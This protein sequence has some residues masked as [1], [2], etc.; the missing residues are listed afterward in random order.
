MSHYT[1]LVKFEAEKSNKLEGVGNIITNMLAPY[2]ENTNVPQYI[3]K[4]KS[5]AK[6]YLQENIDEYKDILNLP[7]EK[8]KSYN[9]EHCQ[10]MYDKFI[11][12]TPEEWWERYTCK[13]DYKDEDGNILSSYNPNSKWDW[14]QI[15][16][17]WSGMLKL[18]KEARGLHGEGSLVYGNKPGIDVAFLKDVDFKAIDQETKDER[19]KDWDKFQKR[20]K[21]GK[22]V[23]EVLGFMYDIQK[24]DTKE[25][26]IKRYTPFSTYAVLDKDGWHSSGKMG[27]W[28]M[29]SETP[30]EKAEFVDHFKK[31][32]LD[33]YT[34][35]TVIA[36][37]DCHIWDGGEKTW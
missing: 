15:G 6:E 3:E 30:D 27:W 36:I 18:K 37:L 8:R 26:Y 13:D 2:D 22:E 21:S 4:Y 11:K 32:F 12:M 14:W 7:E 23:K 28:G 10:K 9:I 1:V 5:K 31:R 17:R 34:D 20:L 29:S 19:A 24:G 25:I 33:T 35:K 16:G